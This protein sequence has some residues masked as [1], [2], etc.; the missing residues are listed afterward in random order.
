MTHKNPTVSKYGREAL[1][2]KGEKVRTFSRLS[3]GG[4]CPFRGLDAPLVLVSA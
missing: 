3:V 4:H 1:S 2:T